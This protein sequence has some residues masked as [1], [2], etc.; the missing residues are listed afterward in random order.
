MWRAPF[1]VM[2]PFLEHAQTPLQVLADK[3]IAPFAQRRW[4]EAFGLVIDL[5]VDKTR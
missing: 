5:M 4:N 3:A 2:I 1:V